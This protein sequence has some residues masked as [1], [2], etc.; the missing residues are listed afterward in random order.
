VTDRKLLKGVAAK[1]YRKKPLL[2]KGRR[3]GGVDHLSR[4]DHKKR[5]TAPTSRKGNF[6]TRWDALGG[7]KLDQ[8]IRTG[9]GE[10]RPNLR[11]VRP[12]WSLRRNLL[13]EKG[14]RLTISKRRAFEKRSK[15]SVTGGTET[16]E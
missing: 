14:S 16:I 9:F 7:K 6:L 12:R 5:R 13:R 8:E 15:E 4:G 3:R 2:I 1:H 10:G 11:G